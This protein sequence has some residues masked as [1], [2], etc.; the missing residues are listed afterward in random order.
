M[1]SW[2]LCPLGGLVSRSAAPNFPKGRAEVC[3]VLPRGL[4]L[5]PR[6][7]FYYASNVWSL[8]VAITLL[9][10]ESWCLLWD[11]RG[12]QVSGADPKLVS[13]VNI[14]QATKA[15]P[16]GLGLPAREGL[17]WRSVVAG[18]EFCFAFS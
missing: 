3:V 5:R 15:Q 12:H 8:T 13:T 16:S 1:K 14:L 9:L 2:L 6:S 4:S 7:T 17:V 11:P 18:G 10:I